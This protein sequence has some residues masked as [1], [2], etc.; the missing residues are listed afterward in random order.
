[1]TKWLTCTALS[2]AAFVCG[3][4]E[5]E[6]T[7][8]LVY[9]GLAAETIDGPDGCARPIEQ[10]IKKVHDDDAASRIAVGIRYLVTVELKG[11]ETSCVAGLEGEALA[12]LAAV[13]AR[14]G[15]H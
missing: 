13:R 14:Y 10:F 15:Y 1:M 9:V 3:G 6:K 2:L 11:A 5:P 8:A 7:P 4:C 12:Q